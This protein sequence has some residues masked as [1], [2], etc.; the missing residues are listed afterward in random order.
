MVLNTNTR[1]AGAAQ[2]L[3]GA[4]VF[5]RVCFRA[6]GTPCELQFIA[7]DRATARA[8]S[9]EAVRWV[10][11]FEAKYSRYR[12][13]SLIG[14]INAAAGRGWV[15]VDA[16]AERMFALADQV[17]LL[18]GG[19]ID[20][21]ALPLLRLWDFRRIPPR[22]PSREEVA[23]ALALVGWPR[24]E[25][26]PGRI[27][28]PERGMGLDLGGFGKE[29]AVDCV[30]GLAAS[31]GLTAFLVDF[32]HDVRV[33]GGPPGLPCWCIG[34]EHPGRPGTMRARLALSSGGVA[35]SGDYLR[36]FEIGGRRYG[37]IVDPRTGH[38]PASDCRAVTVVAG[39]CLEAGL[40]TTTA[41][42]LG[43]DEGLRLIDSHP[44]AEGSLHCTDHE[45]Q[46]R[47]YFRHVL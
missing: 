6:L 20:A 13:D 18:T 29:W 32:G 44:G 17:H 39:T 10:D 47:G 14:R 24:V 2:P 45:R 34:V 4:A 11:A 28:L 33:R 38:P 3:P 40:L 36:G 15:E 21:S 42:L 5:E 23:A 8:F 43:P 22:V 35:T 31:H 19:I 30:A 9:S 7:P 1:P 46:T 37:H 16:G 25:R 26:E 41:F 12:P 27:R